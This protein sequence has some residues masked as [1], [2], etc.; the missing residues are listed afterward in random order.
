MAITLKSLLIAAPF[1]EETRQKLLPIVDD[2][3]QEHK[4]RLS[5]AAW[6]G[7]SQ[8]FNAQLMDKVDKLLLEVK[9]GRRVYNVN[10][11]T[12]VKAKLINEYAKKLESAET[13][14]DIEEVRTQLEKIKQE[15]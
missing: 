11:F 5:K 10:D 7:L 2:L 14:E 13:Q 15:K 8:M 9:D 12:E 1:P 6:L 4:M 3:S